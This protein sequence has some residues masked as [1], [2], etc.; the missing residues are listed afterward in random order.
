MVSLESLGAGLLVAALGVPFLFFPETLARIRNF[1][2]S[3]PTPTKGGVWSMRF[4][5]VMLVIFGFVAVF[6]Y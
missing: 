6:A 5:G 2:A 3:D 1:H 4:V